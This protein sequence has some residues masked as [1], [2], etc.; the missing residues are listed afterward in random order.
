[1]IGGYGG[2]AACALSAFAGTIVYMPNWCE[3]DITVTSY[4]LPELAALQQ[5]VFGSTDPSA[6]TE[7]NQCSLLDTFLP[8]P[9]ALVDTTS[10]SR[11]PYS[12]KQIADCTDATMRE[13]MCRA[14]ARHHADAQALCDMVGFDNWYDWSLATWGTK[15]PDRI[16]AAERRPRSLRITGACPWSPPVPGLLRISQMFPSLRFTIDYF[17]AGMGF[18]GK[19]VIAA[20]E[21]VSNT[22][23]RYR[24]SRGG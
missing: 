22:S 16:Y 7:A 3:H 10:P 9:E 14:V 4:N 17:E 23:R 6:V 24:G 13:Q 21:I 5:E 20:G 15:W 18:A 1:M 11:P 12:D 2:L 19:I 8:V